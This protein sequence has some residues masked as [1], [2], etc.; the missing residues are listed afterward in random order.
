MKNRAGAAVLL[1]LLLFAG[2][3][4]GQGNTATEM[5]IKAAKWGDLKGTE[6][7][8]LAGTDPNIVNPGWRTP[9][10][11]AAL[12]N[13]TDVAA[14]LL[15]HHADPNTKPSSEKP[16]SDSPQ[17]PLQIAASKGNL[18]MASILAAAG[19]QVDTKTETGRTA[20][21][22]AAVGGYS[23]VVRFL[24][25]KGADINVRDVHG[26]SPLDDTVWRGH[27]EA[28]AILLSD[29]APLDRAVKD[30][31]ATP[32]NEAAFRGQTEVLRY[33]LGLHPNLRTPDRRGYNP[34]EN[35]VRMGHEE[36]AVLL[37]EVSP[38]EQKT[39]TFL[40]KIL[41]AAI[42]KDE[43]RV[44]E[45]LLSDGVKV[46]DTLPNEAL[47]LNYAASEGAGKVVRVLLNAGAPTDASGPDGI[48]PLE[49]A[50]LKGFDSVAQMLLDSGASLNAA[51]SVSGETAL[52]AAAAFGRRDVVQLL[53]QRGAD[54]NLCSKDHITP[55]KAAVLNGYPD[56][57]RQIQQ[58]GGS[59]TCR[60]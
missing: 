4:R 47:P 14:L 53:L 45:K 51:N 26:V 57:A 52:Y 8:L 25:D 38:Q 33:L 28:T 40:S 5:L 49:D 29:G 34:L 30:T 12:Y 46:T 58:L 6:T 1:A 2:S 16:N 41:G 56:V 17:T 19:A 54:P 22:F 15:A 24:I 44:V 20:L 27:L 11:Y 43:S 37:L 23:D 7:L 50:C 9:L 55:Y 36:A 3:L 32:V 10:C 35:S 13:R 31:G 59:A 18:Q 42:T 39:P 60:P 48:T 21:H